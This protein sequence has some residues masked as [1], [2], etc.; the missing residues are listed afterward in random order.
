MKNSKAHLSRRNFIR[1]SAGAFSAMAALPASVSSGFAEPP[2]KF[3]KIYLPPDAPLPVKTAAAELAAG[4]GAMV[5]EQKHK[6]KVH[7]GEIILAVGDGVSAYKE[8]AALLPDPSAHR[9][10]ELV[11]RAS[12]GLL[13]AGTTPRNVCRAALGWMENPARE[14]DRLSVYRFTERV[15]MWDNALNQMYRFSEGFDRRRHIREIAR[16]GHTG[17]E[18]NRY[19]DPGGWFVRNRKFE[20]DSYVWYMSYAPALDAFVES[21]LTKGLYPKEDLSANL[22]D[23]VA[24]VEIAREYGLMPSF[25]CYEPRAVNEKIFDRYPGLRG[26]RVERSGP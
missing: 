15:T 26:S 20:H 19:A 5:V 4:T 25:M 2:Q 10:W 9:E 17:I 21:S 24:G 13:I 11:T 23:M 7:S 6:G 16:L 12:G 22:A 14:T 18:I 1:R 8:A 3:K